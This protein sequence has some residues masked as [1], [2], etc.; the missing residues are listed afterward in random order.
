MTGTVPHCAGDVGV[1]VF[2]GC[3]FRLF[4]TAASGLTF[5]SLAELAHLSIFGRRVAAPRRVGRQVVEF[6]NMSVTWRER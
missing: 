5:V 3:S 4:F 6:A 2:Q 1:F